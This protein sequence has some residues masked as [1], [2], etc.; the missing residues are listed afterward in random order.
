MILFSK[1]PPDHFVMDVT[2]ATMDKLVLVDFN[3]WGVTSRRTCL[4]FIRESRG[5]QL[6]PHRHYSIYRDM[7]IGGTHVNQGWH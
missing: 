6:H 3:S 1:V 2:V 7:V 4:R 5:V